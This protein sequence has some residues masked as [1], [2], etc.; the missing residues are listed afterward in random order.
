MAGLWQEGVICQI[1][2]SEP[3][4]RHL[5]I[6][7]GAPSS[8]AQS[9]SSLWTKLADGDQSI[10]PTAVRLNSWCL[11]MESASSFHGSP[12]WPLTSQKLPWVLENHWPRM[13]QSRA[14]WGWVLQFHS[15]SVS[16]ALSRKSGRI[17]TVCWTCEQRLAIRAAAAAV[18]S[19]EMLSAWVAPTHEGSAE[20]I[21]TSPDAHPIKW[22]VPTLS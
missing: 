3:G 19:A 22:G 16:I 4:G 5:C 6:H 20:A 10:V 15:P 1:P 2:F 13:R 9:K 17:N 8:H 7:W 18:S 21:T 12:E 11:A 14:S